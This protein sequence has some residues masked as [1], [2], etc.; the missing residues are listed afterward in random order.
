MTPLCRKV[1]IGLRLALFA[2]TVPLALAAL[3]LIWQDYNARHDAIIT[4]VELKSA[5]INAQLE[6]FV[7]R[8][9]AATGVF[10][11]NWVDNHGPG[12]PDSRELATTNAYLLRLA[13]DRPEFS[14]A[15]I[16]DVHG[17]VVAASDSSIIGTRIGD[18]ALF[19][20]AVA[21][22]KFTASDV[23][24][25][26]IGETPPYAQFLQPLV[27][28]GGPIQ[29]FLV[30]KSD[31][32]TISGSLDMSVGFPESAKSGIFDSSGK[33]LAGTGYEA[34]HPGMA[35]GRDVSGSAVWAQAATQPTNEW[36]GLGLDKVERIIFFGY[37]DSTPW[38]TTV[39]YSQSEL[40]DPLW[41]RLMTF[42]GV[43]GITLIA[44][45][46]VGEIFV[47][48]E[49][50]NVESIETERVTLD[51]VMNGAT[52][53]IMVIDNQDSV[54]FTN[55]SLAELIGLE[56][57][58]LV[59]RSVQDAMALIADLGDDPED[60][61]AQL[62]D[63]IKVD[64]RVQVAHLAMKDRIGV[65]FEITS[66]PVI[67]EGGA[68]LGRTLV[69]HDVSKAKAVSRMKS[70]FLM[71]ASHQLRTPMASILTFAELSISR[72]APPPKQ[73][74]WMGLIQ[75]Q[76]T[77]MVET[78]NSML[79]VS[80]IESGRLELTVE[81]VDAG[82]AS[83]TIVKEF[84]A[85]SPN[86]VFNVDIPAATAMIKAD[87]VRLNQILQNLVDNAVKYSPE[88]G[89]VDITADTSGSGVVHFRVS[90][91]GIGI[92]AEAQRRLFLPFSRVSDEQTSAVNGSGLGLY[93]ARNLVKQHGGEMWLESRPGVGT[94]VHFTLPAAA[95]APEPLQAA[96]VRGL[97]NSA[98][99]IFPSTSV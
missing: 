66:Y 10:A 9:D 50:R 31:L 4:Q 60:A 76:A 39:A 96:K 77:R 68:L 85:G 93:I 30:T 52:D 75:Q 71:T 55:R 36:F 38:V 73:R 43:L 11:A 56:P 53:G 44:A 78:I 45:V 54:N 70:Q 8:I 91:T 15:S 29:A 83:R 6:D 25:E 90:D 27:W 1:C 47:R 94:T 14:A 5:Q 20:R 21:A 72:E 62:G 51:A 82:E 58:S 19:D 12:A 2:L 48:R 35:A 59:Q 23:F 92:T 80:E 17:V 69:F 88:A 89:I 64:S 49:R 18:E 32:S 24:V 63:A 97:G 99:A 34:P 86:H 26:E 28:D 84:E 79:N 57:D 13:D 42:A 61:G 40:F 87:S 3:L 33:I 22:G 98:P 46:V 16:T 41:D 7:H 37:P 67:T 74:Q 95:S 81:D 65:E